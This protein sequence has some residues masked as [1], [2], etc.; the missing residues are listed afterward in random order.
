MQLH[1]GNLPVGTLSYFPTAEA[2]HSA[3]KDKYKQV[4]E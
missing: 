4:W 2:I 1:E 3:W